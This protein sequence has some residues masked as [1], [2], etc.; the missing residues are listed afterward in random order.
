MDSHQDLTDQHDHDES[1]MSMVDDSVM[2]SAEPESIVTSNGHSVEPEDVDVDVEGDGDGTDEGDA[3]ANDDPEDD[4]GDLAPPSFS[5]VASSLSAD[6][7][8]TAGPGSSSILPAAS[9]F[10]A[11]SGGRRGPRRRQPAH[12]PKLRAR[13]RSITEKFLPVLGEIALA[14]VGQLDPERLS[15]RINAVYGEL[16]LLQ[17]FL[18]GEA[19]DDISLANNNIITAIP[20]QA[21]SAVVAGNGH[22]NGNGVAQFQTIQM[23]VVGP[24]GQL[25][26]SRQA[27]G[28]EDYL[29]E[30]SSKRVKLGNDP[31][32]MMRPIF[33]GIVGVDGK[34][35]LGVVLSG[36]SVNP[37]LPATDMDLHVP[38]SQ[39]YRVLPHSARAT[40]ESGTMSL[41]EKR[42]EKLWAVMQNEIYSFAVG[43]NNQLLRTTSDFCLLAY[44]QDGRMK[45]TLKNDLAI[46]EALFDGIS[47]FRKRLYQTTAPQYDENNDPL[48]PNQL[49]D[50]GIRTYTNNLYN[51]KSKP[52]NFYHFL[53]AAAFW[54]WVRDEIDSK[55]APASAL[56]PAT[57]AA[58]VAVA[59]GAV[60]QVGSIESANDSGNPINSAER[61]T[62][63]DL[64]ESS[65]ADPSKDPSPPQASDNQEASSEYAV[66]TIDDWWRECVGI[67]NGFVKTNTDKPEIKAFLKERLH[68]D[69]LKYPD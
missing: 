46:S 22:N 28:G 32:D 4:E 65:A 5:A 24:D 56:G 19:P 69:E 57:A 66:N 14:K 23:Q 18:D 12:Y 13:V 64:A 45:R 35:E 40:Y 20:G 7:S 68:A 10:V 36:P 8:V 39:L 49:R 34:D 41:N 47:G 26:A 29:H 55:T 16:V 30:P 37:N 9:T 62:A 6:T 21:G 48:P 38:V 27:A 60:D 67:C 59:V 58:A 42:R 50:C 15:L 44:S 61:H 25:M 11:T 63:G 43:Y 51:L 17:K 52:P 53:F 1:V 33:Q 54:R 2:D 31:D 3:D